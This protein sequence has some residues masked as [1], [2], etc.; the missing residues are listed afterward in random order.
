MP[1]A[2]KD[3]RDNLPETFPSQVDCCI[4]LTAIPSIPLS[5][6]DVRAD[7]ARVVFKNGQFMMTINW[8]PV[9]FVK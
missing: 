3:N 1:C 6:I 7:H 5:M 4:W 9:K 8:V 2:R